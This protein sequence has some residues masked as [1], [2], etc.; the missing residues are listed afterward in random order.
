MGGFHY[1]TCGNMDVAGPVTLLVVTGPTDTVAR[2]QVLV[3]L[4]RKGVVYEKTYE[5]ES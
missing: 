4:F 3:P 1:P 2:C 5:N